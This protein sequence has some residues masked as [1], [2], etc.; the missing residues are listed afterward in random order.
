M[1]APREARAWRPQG[2]GR[3]AARKI[4]DP[5]VEPLWIGDRAIAYA[6]ADRVE[7]LD[8]DGEAFVAELVADVADA[9][10][11]AVRADALVLDGYLTVQATRPPEAVFLGMEAPSSSDFATQLLVGQ[12][13]RP[14]VADPR[15]PITADA[16]LAFVA[17]DILAVDEESLLDIPLL[18]RKRILESV[19]EES[20]L[21]RVGAYVRPPIDTW[22]ATWRAL[23]FGALAFKASNSRYRPGRSNDEWST[24][25][26]PAR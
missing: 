19:L 25:R 22:L 6:A 18:E 13:R 24:A 12:R 20:E 16:P 3:K 26:I 1:V 8:E 5:I 7:L 23:G 10:R 11:N 15:L 21:V 17:V 9:I 4:E 2:F 14:E